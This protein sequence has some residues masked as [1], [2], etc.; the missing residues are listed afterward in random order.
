MAS[1]KN[2]FR[3]LMWITVGYYT[4]RW[5]IL[6]ALPYAAAGENVNVYYGLSYSYD[7]V[8]L[9]F[10]V[11]VI[12]LVAKTRK[13]VRARYVLKNIMDCCGV[14]NALCGSENMFEG[15]VS[16]CGNTD[17]HRQ[18][19]ERVNKVPSPRRKNLLSRLRKKKNKAASA[20][21]ANLDET[22]QNRFVRR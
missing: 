22:L 21:Y 15:L 18:A 17:S 3:T 6:Y 5:S 4:I 16:D 9:I 7:I 12:I 19:K 11:F 13:K 2:A 10:G 14:S 1:T 20:G 8:R